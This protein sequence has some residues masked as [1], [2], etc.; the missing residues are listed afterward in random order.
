M[1]VQSSWHLLQRSSIFLKTLINSFREPAACRP[2]GCCSLFF[3]SAI[4]DHSESLTKVIS[5][6]L[7]NHIYRRRRLKGGWWMRN[8]GLDI[9]L[10]M[11]YVIA[12]RS[13]GQLLLACVTQLPG[14]W[15]NI[16][17]YSCVQKLHLYTSNLIKINRKYILTKSKV[18]L[19]AKDNP[20]VFVA[21][22][23]PSSVFY[24]YIEE[25]V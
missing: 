22:C 21:T 20:V 11:V 3:F 5:N 17:Y 23:L 12:W 14:P 4:I 1:C 2:D 16:L 8:I 19:I 10:W 24:Q 7:T 25:T 15:Y 13:A 6:K 9:G 18:V